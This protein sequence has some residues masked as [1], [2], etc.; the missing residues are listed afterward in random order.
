MIQSEWRSLPLAVLIRLLF[1]YVRSAI[2]H[3]FAKRFVKKAMGSK[4]GK[5]GKKRQKRNFCPFCLFCFSSGYGAR[6]FA[7]VAYTGW[8]FS[9][10][11]YALLLRIARKEAPT[12]SAAM[13]SINPIAIKIVPLAPMLYFATPGSRLMKNA[14]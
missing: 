14:M 11:C 6:T 8:K 5:K 10:A 3:S 1:P 4:K 7:A 2:R 12:P 13:S 9:G